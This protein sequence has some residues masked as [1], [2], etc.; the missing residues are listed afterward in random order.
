MCTFLIMFW[1]FHC[2]YGGER[3]Q[4]HSPH[5]SNTNVWYALCRANYLDPTIS[6]SKIIVGK[7]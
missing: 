1:V 7:K 3:D 2:T 5:S 6:N 4:G